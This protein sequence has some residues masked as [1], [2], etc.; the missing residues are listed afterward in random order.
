MTD[1]ERERIAVLES[2]VQHLNK[3]I[4]K[5]SR[6]QDEMYNLMMQTKGGWKTLVLLAALSGVVGGALVKIGP[7]L[8]YLPK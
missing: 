4:E 8:G 6:R 1:N 5:M 3:A 7:Y 2:E